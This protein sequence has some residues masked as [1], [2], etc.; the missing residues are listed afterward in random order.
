MRVL[1]TTDVIGGVWTYTLELVRAL[2]PHGVEAVVASMG[3]RLSTEQRREAAEAGSAAVFASD[4]ALE[5]MRDRWNEVGDAGEWLLRVRD[6]V[7]PDLVHLNGYVH[8]TL[9]WRTPVLVA[10][11]SCVYSWFAA[12]RGRRPGREWERYRNA[13]ELGLRAAD[14]VVA[15]SE[16]MLRALEEHYDFRSERVVIHNG[17]T[18]LPS[19][20]KEPYVLAAGRAWDRAKNLA[21]VERVAP[22][23]RWPVTIVGPGSPAGVAPRTQL[24]ALFARASIFCAPARYEPFGLAP[25]EAAHAGCALVL[26]DIASLREVWGDAATYVDPDDER[27]LERALRQL[28]E[29]DDLRREQARR[30]RTRAARYTPERMADRYAALY[31]RLLAP[32]LEE[33]A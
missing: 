4:S 12:V 27:A 33:V 6:E 1:I 3:G 29:D 21:L 26:G 16:A 22:R 15:P 14:V 13:V 30:A 8:A 17:R 5:W 24:D 32:H 18:S 11:H 9:P 10:G 19:R 20:P 28:I 25:L 2:R 7:D 31:V 23:L